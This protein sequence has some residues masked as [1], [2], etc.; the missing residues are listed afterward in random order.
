MPDP[1]SPTDPPR[2]PFLTSTFNTAQQEI[3]RRAD[4]L[5]T[6]LQLLTDLQHVCQQPNEPFPYPTTLADKKRQFEHLRPQ[7]EFLTQATDLLGTYD[8]ESNLLEKEG[9]LSQRFRTK[10]EDL[11]SA[12]V[13]LAEVMS[14]EKV[15][16]RK[17]VWSR[18]AT[19]EDGWQG[20]RRLATKAVR[21]QVRNTWMLG[22]LRC[23]RW[24]SRTM[25]KH[26]G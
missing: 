21:T 26:G 14:R 3:S 20:K 15:E 1:S 25:R 2:K 5:F 6:D 10:A 11:D 23:A 12:M 9:R 18:W 24:A 17:A 19:V 13:G 22:M 4:A 16:A 7:A 8:E